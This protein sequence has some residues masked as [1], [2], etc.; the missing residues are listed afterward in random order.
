MSS[1][2]QFRDEPLSWRDLGID[3]RGRF[4][5]QVK[6][7]CPKCSHTRRHKRDLC[8]SVNLDKE[9]FNCHHCGWSGG[10]G[11]GEK[12]QSV[13]P[14]ERAPKE[15]TKPTPILTIDQ[16]SEQWMRSILRGRGLSDQTINEAKVTTS[17]VK[18]DDEILDTIAFPYFRDG[19]I[20]NYKYYRPDPVDGKKCKMVYNAERLWYGLDWCRDADQIIITEGEIDALSFREAGYQ[21]V[22]SVPDGAPNPN[23]KD[24]TKK[25]EY[26]DEASPLFNEAAIVIIA[27]DADAPGEF[28]AAELS[29]RIGKNKCFRMSF[30]KG[31]K[32]GNDVLAKYG[33]EELQRCV[34]DADPWPVEGVVQAK[35]LASK[36]M[37]I[38]SGNYLQGVT[39]GYPSLDKLFRPALGQMTVIVGVPQHGK[40]LST[41]TPIPTPSG[42]TTMGQLRVG[43]EVID[44]SG[45]PCRVTFATPV[46]YGHD[47]FRVRFADGSEII[48][49]AEHQWLTISESARRSESRAMAHAR[50]RPDRSHDWRDQSHKRTYAS[51]VTT[52][53]IAE[54]LEHRGRMNHQIPLCGPLDLPDADLPIDPYILGVWLGDGNTNDGIIHCADDEIVDALNAAGYPAHR[55]DRYRLRIH[56]RGL[57]TKLRELGVLGNKHVPAPYLRGSIEQRRSL[58]AGLLDTDGSITSYGR[59][60]FCSTSESLADAVYELA[61]SLGFA[62]KLL[63]DRASLH[64]RDC[65]P[66]YRVT[67][68][69]HGPVFRLSRKQRHVHDAPTRRI[70]KRRAIVSVEP[71]L[72]VPVR[73]IQVDS[74][75]SLFLCGK[76]MIPTHNTQFVDSLMLQ[77]CKLHGWGFG[78][79]S[80]ENY[81]PELHLTH[82]IQRLYKRKITDISDEEIDKAIIWLNRNVHIIA[83]DEPTLTSILDRASILVQRSGIRALTIDPWTEVQEEGEN[84]QKFIKQGLTKIGQAKRNHDMHIFVTVHP[85]KLQEERDIDGMVKTSKPSGYDIADSAHFV[86]KADNVISIW[87]DVDREGAPIE[88]S[89]IKARFRERGQRG[90]M[91]MSYDPVSQALSDGGLAP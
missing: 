25:F 21:A 73:C 69:P 88:V 10:L 7:L 86:N 90:T 53:E 50:V 24:Y 38:K 14:P 19:E 78:V 56:T 4:S 55:N 9:A 72:S 67:F 74:P 57:H 8:L 64:G 30:P 18:F 3:T 48:A 33:V 54:T 84:T 58:L 52:R 75:M 5:G 49:D 81:P 31:C 34:Q 27:T 13:P 32:D 12:T 62:A 80:P 22:L 36:V 91:F 65:G 70:G 28:L 87:R 60:E 51:V 47:C 20:V 26:Y 66:R 6:T 76:G 85:R 40:A 82:L 43:D 45:R 23:S 2:V 46:M 44:Q 41:D 77:L 17:R 37:M 16:K 1:V 79:F 29:R 89:V 11:R 39:T 42:W 61:I 15:Y 63:I 83:P 71:T 35:S 68:T 59:V